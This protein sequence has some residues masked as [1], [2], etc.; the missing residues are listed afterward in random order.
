[1][2]AKVRNISI[3]QSKTKSKIRNLPVPL[4][5][6]SR[7]FPQLGFEQNNF[8]IVITESRSRTGGTAFE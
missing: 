7:D 8:F 3:L 4:K 6:A 1:M 5:F 2:P